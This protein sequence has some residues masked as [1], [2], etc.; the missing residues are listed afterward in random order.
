[1]RK[2]DSARA[3]DPARAMIPTVVLTV[4][5]DGTVTATIDGEPLSPPDGAMP[6]RRESF[7]PIID[8]ASDDRAIPVRVE[9]READGSVFTDLIPA[10]PHRSRPPAEPKH[11]R[12]KPS[13]RQ[14]SRTIEG[15][16]FMPGEDVTIAIITGHTNAAHTGTAR[17]LIDPADPIPDHADGRAEVLLLGSISGTTVIRPLP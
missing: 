5:A 6:W 8:R 15:D 4:G 16:G 3:H 13:T 14:T 10:R 17:G 9:V 2:H 1:M 11:A 7:G 12:R